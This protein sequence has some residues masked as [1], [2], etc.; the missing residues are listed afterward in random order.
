M[1]V[2]LPSTSFV[3]AVRQEVFDEQS[4][5][6]RWII[7]GIS[8]AHDEPFSFWSVENQMAADLIS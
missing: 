5:A 8:D 1:L 6:P 7:A 3:F 4:A 2:P